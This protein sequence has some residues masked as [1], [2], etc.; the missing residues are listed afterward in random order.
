MT[1][2]A[3]EAKRDGLVALVED[4]TLRAVI[5]PALRRKL[6]D[7][8]SPFRKGSPISPYQCSPL[9]SDRL[10]HHIRAPITFER[11]R[12][13]RKNSGFPAKVIGAGIWTYRRA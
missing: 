11:P 2:E 5:T 13:G 8:F 4:L 10:S 7:S 1:I 9:R 6:Y 12:S 3:W